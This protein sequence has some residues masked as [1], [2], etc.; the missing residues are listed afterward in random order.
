METLEIPTFMLNVTELRMRELQIE[1][2]SLKVDNEMLRNVDGDLR[3]NINNLTAENRLL[4]RQ[5]I[6]LR[7]TVESLRLTGADTK[8][9]TCK[10]MTTHPQLIPTLLQ[11]VFNA[12]P[13][14]YENICDSL[15]AER[16]IDA[17]KTLRNAT[18]LGLKEAKDAIDAFALLGFR[19]DAEKQ[20]DP[21]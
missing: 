4:E 2:G 6:D 20:E 13:S 11:V 10:L 12:D 17:I 8:S 15:E 1:L 7:A 5:F 16:K 3:Y 9:V 18:N 19:K 21:T 14:V